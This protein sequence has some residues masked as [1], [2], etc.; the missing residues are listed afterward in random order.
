MT[1]ENYQALGGEDV[2]SQCLM[3]PIK[4]GKYI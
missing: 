4:H 3:E 1:W 2:F